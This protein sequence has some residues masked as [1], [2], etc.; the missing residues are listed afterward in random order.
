MPLR[1]AWGSQQ[2]VSQ[3]RT[4]HSKRAPQLSRYRALHSTCPISLIAKQKTMSAHPSPPAPH[5]AHP[6]NLSTPLIETSTLEP[7]SQPLHTP[8]S[9]Y[10]IRPRS[11]T[12]SQPPSLPQHNTL[13]LRQHTHAHPPTTYRTH[14]HPQ[15][16]TT[17]ILTGLAWPATAAASSCTFSTTW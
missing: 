11:H 16:H 7:S 2:A 1:P 17:R 12:P 10:P 9:L 5:Q 8:N 14:A 6:P 4:R 13:I 3:Y 15:Q